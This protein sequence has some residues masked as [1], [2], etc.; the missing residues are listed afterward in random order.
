[1]VVLFFDGHVRF[2]ECRDDGTTPNEDLTDTDSSGYAAVMDTDIYADGNWYGGA[3]W[4]SDET[5]DC[6]LGNVVDVE[7]DT[8]DIEWG[9]GP[10]E[11]P[12]DDWDPVN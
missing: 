4:D 10:N 3:N 11:T 9:D 2:A 8:E 1:V 7:D 12:Y 6:N 5:A